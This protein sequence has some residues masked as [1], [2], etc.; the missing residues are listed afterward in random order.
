M[1]LSHRH[2]RTDTHASSEDRQT[3]SFMSSGRF[4]LFLGIV[5]SIWA[6]LHLY[7]LWRLDSVPGVATHLS[8]RA[9]IVIAAALWAGYP[10][11][12]I[13]D[14][15]KLK[16]LARPLEIVAATWIGI[17]FLLFATLL[18]ADVFTLGG[19]LLPRLAP[20]I[21]GGAAIAA[22]VLSLIGLVQGLRPAV[23]RDHE[24]RLAG[25]PP[26]RDGLVLVEISDL[27]L[28]TMTGQRWLTRLVKRVNDMR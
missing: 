15:W 10:L 28:G 21:R 14:S 22:G 7:V 9:L 18:A 27:H 20:T 4:A 17:L 16:A 25:L 11:A 12:R 5:L 24:V 1:D 19:W 3:K 2:D 6:A 8:T 23:V 13:L 26:E